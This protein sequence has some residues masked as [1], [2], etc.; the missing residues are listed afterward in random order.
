[1]KNT[2]KILTRKLTFWKN[3]ERER[4][5]SKIGQFALPQ[6]QNEAN[7]WYP[8]K[9]LTYTYITPLYLPFRNDCILY[10]DCN[11][12]LE[13]APLGHSK[14]KIFPKNWI[15]WMRLQIRTN[16]FTLDITKLFFSCFSQMCLC[17]SFCEFNR[18]RHTKSRKNCEMS[19]ANKH[20]NI[21]RNLQ[22]A[23]QTA[24]RPRE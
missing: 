18:F 22:R 5:M 7:I 14:T 9:A 8:K 13:R 24:D 12:W 11:D 2:L 15:D 1:M 4:K 17:L 19:W 21:T 23:T 3:W 10:S 16:S 20:C 6:V